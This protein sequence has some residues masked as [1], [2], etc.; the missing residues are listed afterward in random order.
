MEK[1][2][3]VF[4]DLDNTLWKGVVAEGVVEPYHYLFELIDRLNKRG[5]V[6]SIVSHNKFEV[7][8][9]YLKTLGYWDYFVLPKISWDKKA[10]QILKS[11][12]Q[13]NLRPENAL[14]IDDR[15]HNLEEAKYYIPEINTLNPIDG[16]L[17]GYLGN[18]A[19]IDGKDD[20]D[21]SRYNQYKLLEK[22]V[23]EQEKVYLDDEEAFLR[24]SNIKVRFEVPN[25]H[26]DRIYELLSRTNQLNY[27][28]RRSTKE[29]VVELIHNTNFEKYAISVS[30]KFGD[31]G[32]VGF[33]AFNKKKEKVLHFTFSC[34]ILNMG[35]ES[36]LFHYFSVP[37][38]KYVGD[39]AYSLQ[40]YKP[41]WITINSEIK[42]DRKSTET[43]KGLM[44]GG[45]DLEQMISF[46]PGTYDKHFNY[47]SAENKKLIVHRDSIDILLSD[48]LTSEQIDFILSTCP[49]LDR[50]CFKLPDFSK[51]SKIIYSPLIDYIQGK[52]ISDSIPGYYVSCNPYLQDNNLTEEKIKLISKHKGIS[53]GRQ[54]TFNKNWCAVKKPNDVYIQQLHQLFRKFNQADVIVL[55][56]A[57]NTYSK[58]DID[59]VDI[60]KKMNTII[61]YVVDQYSNINVVEPD[62]YINKK[63]DFTNAIRH[64]KRH[65]YYNMAEEINKIIRFY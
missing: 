11:L 19:G 1:L 55:L 29:E 56:G 10:P 40:N 25:Y 27:T 26:I 46:L 22:K 64:Y 47:V 62:K 35:V 24:D 34:R 23:E 50:N 2:K 13:M 38:F 43:D 58:L 44:V 12:N 16:D 42:I 63:E 18:K 48:W 36:F 6:N 32:V 28:K 9:N 65:V 60:H 4:W 17:V 39:V 61:K 21:L 54:I 14:F 49:F 53:R 20:H 5:I 41:D 3:V 57:T 33:I 30:D 15:G 59:K 7:A 37:Y 8:E 45:C 31:Y 51:Y 52:Y